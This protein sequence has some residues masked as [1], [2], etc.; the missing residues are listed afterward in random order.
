MGPEMNDPAP[1]DTEAGS[2]SK[3]SSSS[4]LISGSPDDDKVVIAKFWK[5]RN[6]KEHVVVALRKW[7]DLPLLDVRVFVDDQSGCS[8]PSK[9]GVAITIHKLPELI[10]ALQRANDRAEEMG[11]FK[12]RQRP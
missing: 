3:D 7:N 4:D 6:R 2:E 10:S 5:S 12:A 11:W 1:G 8:R 9:K